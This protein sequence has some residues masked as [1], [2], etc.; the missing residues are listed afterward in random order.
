M[1]GRFHKTD[2]GLVLAVSLLAG[3]A[4]VSVTDAQVQTK[5]QRAKVGEPD[6]AKGVWVVRFEP[7]GDFAPKTPGEFLAK[8]PIYSGQHGEIGYFRTKKQGDK[9]LGSFLADD[10]DQ[11]KEALSKLPVIKV[12]GVEKLTQEQLVQ[13]K[14]LPQESLMDFDHLDAAKGVWVV[15]FEPVGDF[16]PRTPKEFLAKIPVYSGQ[17]GEIGYFRTKKQGDKLLG[18]FLAYDAEQLKKALS[19]LPVIKVTGVEKLT[20]EGLVQYQKLPQESL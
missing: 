13:Y 20:Q 4:L 2:R 17:H 19:A 14:K 9:L 18:S 12:T 11:L 5:P 1:I 3:L 7:V 15:R 6:A 16:S 8:I 10:G